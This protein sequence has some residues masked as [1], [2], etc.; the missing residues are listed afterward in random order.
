[1]IVMLITFIYMRFLVLMLENNNHPKLMPFLFLLAFRLEAPRPVP[2]EPTLNSEPA[3]LSCTE[4]LNM[5]VGFIWCICLFCCN[6]S[7]SRI[8]DSEVLKMPPVGVGAGEKLGLR[9]GSEG[10]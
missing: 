7:L 3:L 8:R 10:V 4:L 5:E 1:M 2:V 9:A 6:C